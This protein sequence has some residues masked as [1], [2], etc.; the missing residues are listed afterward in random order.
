M[1]KYKVGRRYTRT[2]IRDIENDPGTQ[3]K[4][5]QGYLEHNGEIFIFSN[6]GGKSYTGVDHGD[7]WI[8]KNKG[9]F[10]WNGMKKS[11]IEN[12]NIKMMLDPRIKVHLFVRAVDPKKGD[13]FTYFGIVNPISVSGKDPVNII[14]QIDHTGITFLEN[15]E[16]ENREGYADS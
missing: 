12:K 14:W 9:T 3:G 8:D 6:F 4:W 1:D 10:N 16:I 13:P 7:R 2:E 5:V 11:N 15:D